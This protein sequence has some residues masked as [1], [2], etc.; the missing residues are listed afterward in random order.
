MRPPPEEVDFVLFMRTPFYNRGLA[1]LLFINQRK[2]DLLS[3]LN[4]VREGFASLRVRLS[5]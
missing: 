5:P 4:S 1:V 3:F 2:G